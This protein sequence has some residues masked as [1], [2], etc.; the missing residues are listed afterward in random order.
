MKSIVEQIVQEAEKYTSE[1]NL[2]DYGTAKTH[3]EVLEGRKIDHVETFKK[4]ANFGIEKAFKWIDVKDDM[5]SKEMDFSFVVVQTV[6]KV[7]KDYVGFALAKCYDGEIE[8]L[9]NST[10][11]LKV[12]HWKFINY[13]DRIDHFKK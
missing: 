11:N 10:G 13:E 6:H 4:G 12:T 5:P 2:E 9:D 8:I 1:L 7:V 3:G